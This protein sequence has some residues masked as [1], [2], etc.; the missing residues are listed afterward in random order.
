MDFSNYIP[1]PH[2]CTWQRKPTGGMRVPTV[3]FA[4]RQLI[5]S[6]DA[7]VIKQ[8]E[9]VATLPGIVNAAYAM[10]DAHQGYGF[11]I[12]GVAAF[13]PHQGGVVSAGGVGFDIACGV[14]T[15][16]SDLD[17]TELQSNAGQLVQ[18]LADAVPAGL[19]SRGAIQQLTEPEMEAM[20]TGGA[21]WAVRQGY[22]AD[23]DLRRIE[24]GGTIPDADPDKVSVV[25]RRRQADAMGTLGSGNHYLEVQR[26]AEIYDA[27]AAA[28]FGLREQM[29]VVSIHCGSRGL[30][31]QV[32][33]EYAERMRRAAPRYGLQLPDPELACAPIKSPDGQAYLGAMRA[34]AN[35]ALANRQIITA[36]VRQVFQRMFRNENLPLLYDVSHNLCQ[37]ETFKIDGVQRELYVHRKGATRALPP[38]HRNLPKE[39]KAVGQPVLVGGSMGTSSYVLAGA[40][41]NEKLAFSSACH[42]AGRRLSRT[43]ARKQWRG[44]E[45]LSELARMGITALGHSKAGLAEEAPGAY[46]NIED[47][48]EAA[49]NVGLVIR[50]ARTEPILCL[51]G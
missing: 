42:G 35:C 2:P 17:A 50:V 9:N 26:V 22:G 10:P 39:F 13:D 5:K 24:S 46:K 41:G 11:P 32:A 16:L 19:A 40:A 51:K 27:R 23:A 36:L 1:G 20:L 12:G 38:G 34:A 25:A 47:V 49:T 48:V 28:A 37:A 33:T 7:Q 4:T 3:L 43:Q 8:I 31:H 21:A 30:G 18:A 29:A 45:V 15:L 14:R 6:L 44:A